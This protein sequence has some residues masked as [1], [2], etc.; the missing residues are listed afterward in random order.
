MNLVQRRW[1]AAGRKLKVDVVVWTF[2]WRACVTGLG[3]RED[4]STDCHK[5]I[6]LPHCPRR[7][8]SPVRSLA[9][10]P[11]ST[12]AVHWLVSLG[13][14]RGKIGERRCL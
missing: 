11:W 7:R 2:V 14:G 12:Q 9:V 4:V 5:I 3:R 8:R 6:T 13:Q 10:F 1:N